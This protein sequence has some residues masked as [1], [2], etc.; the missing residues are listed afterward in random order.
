VIALNSNGIEEYRAWKSCDSILPDFRH[1]AVGLAGVIYP[2]SFLTVL[3][4]AGSFFEICCPR[5]DDLWL[6]AQALRSGY[7]VRQ[8]LPR[9]PYF[10]FQGIPGTAGTAL[11]H[12]NVTHGDG[13]DRQIRATYNEADLRLL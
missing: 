7:K 12:E 6:H 13:N 1:V 4:R 3:K 10:S 2:P 5:G 8:I 11:S 9:L